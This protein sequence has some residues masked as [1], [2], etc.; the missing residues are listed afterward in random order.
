MKSEI[1]ELEASEKVLYKYQIV[2]VYIALFYPDVVVEETKNQE[3]NMALDTTCEPMCTAEG[4]EQ[5]DNP[6]I[7]TQNSLVPN[8]DYPV[9]V[10][11]P[12]RVTIIFVSV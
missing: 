9:Q 6:H 3:I 7:N 11:K 2:I 4:G 12:G 10:F 8:I 1:K 5:K